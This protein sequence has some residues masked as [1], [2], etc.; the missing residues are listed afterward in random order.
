ME[1][2]NIYEADIKSTSPP[3]PGSP[4]I[5]IAIIFSIAS[6]LYFAMRNYGLQCVIT[7]VQCMGANNREIGS[8]QLSTWNSPLCRYYSEAIVYISHRI[9]FF[10]NGSERV[11]HSM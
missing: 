11:W 10:Y 3:H 8:L 9:R 2:N 6:N 4:P 7:V 1:L 5:N